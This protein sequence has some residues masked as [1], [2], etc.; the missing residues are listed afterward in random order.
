VTARERILGWLRTA[1]GPISGTALAARLGCSRAAVWKHVDALRAAGHEI[2]G[3]RASGY[4]LACAADPLDPATLG[5]RLTG[6]WRDVEWHEAID[7]TQ[8]RARDLADAGAPEGTVVLADRQSSGRGRLGRTWFSPPGVSVMCTVVLRPPCDPTAVAPLPLVAG[9]AVADA[10]RGATGLAAGLKWPNDVQVGGRKVAGVLA[11]LLGEV[12][13]VS[14]VL[15]GVGLNVNL[16]EDALPAELAPTATSLRIAC[17]RPLDRIDV[18]ARLLAAIEARYARFLAEGFRGMRSEW[19]TLSLL[20]GQEV[21]IV[22][23]GPTVGGRVQGVDDDGALLLGG[24]GGAT[25][26]V[27]AGE[28]SVHRGV[29]R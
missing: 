8:R 26:R 11:E 17:G 1:D 16:R 6:R 27:V 4:V 28:V 20:T 19:N 14:A 22:G 15:L 12:D 24:S 13:R 21:E 2:H 29:G 23:A 9:L 3:A 18:A 7:S 5:P 25:R 10:V